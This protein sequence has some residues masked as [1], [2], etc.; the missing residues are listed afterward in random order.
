MRI[1]PG[2]TLDTV[3][4]TLDKAVMEWQNLQSSR[5]P[6]DQYLR[7]VEWTD[8]VL[9]QFFAEPDLAGGLYDAHFEHIIRGPQH[10]AT[11]RLLAREIERQIERLQQARQELAV[12]R[13]YADRPGTPV[14]YDTNVLVHWRPPNEIK[15]TEV[16]RDQDVRTTQVR[17]VVPLVVIDELDRHKNGSGQLGERAGRAIRY[18]EGAL[19]GSPGVPVSIRDGV[20]LEVRLDRVGHRRG[21]A[22]MEIL[23]CAAELNRLKPEAG[24]RVLSDDFG[25]HLRAQ[26]LDLQAMR[27]PATYRKGAPAAGD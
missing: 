8:R 3:E 19:V 10:H 7:D 14:V 18:L 4:Q 22:D 16:L 25:M 17:L 23:L 24:T 2:F 27:L 21:D 12:L 11:S 26:G 13:A 1:K 20:T 9:S 15:W 5:A 6:W